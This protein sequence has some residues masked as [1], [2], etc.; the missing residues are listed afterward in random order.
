MRAYAVLSEILQRKGDVQNS[1]QS[2]H[3]VAAIRLSEK[4]DALHAAGLYGR[5]FDTYRDALELF[6]DAYCIQSRLAV[7][8]NKQGR[9]REA[10]EH[11][12]RAYEL[13]P[14]SFGRV[15]SHCFGCESVFQDSEAQG[16]AERVFSD[17]IRVTPGKAQAH[18]LLAYLRE[19][20]GDYEGAVQSLRS[21]VG[22]D[23]KYLNAWKRLHDIGDKTYLD[24]G[25]QDI[26]RLKLLELDP[27][28]RHSHY[29]LSE[30]AQ[31]G[32]L[33]RGAAVGREIARR[34]R[35]PSTGVF[36]LYATARARD[37]NLGSLPPE[38]R[39]QI[40]IMERLMESSADAGVARDPA[41]LLRDHALIQNAAAL[42]GL[43]ERLS[44][45]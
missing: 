29:D 44:D 40:S 9:R 12:R 36:A 25:E 11:Y 10:L 17:V 5:A 31:L 27:L 42:M 13:M 21:A 24:P 18:Y 23:G 35:V 8:L 15:E 20:K 4:A 30:V 7:Q 39:E 32:A 3:A 1:E 28:Q 22:I 14:E 34:A 38:M 16:I 33:W 43:Q 19:T 6:S 45:Y 2:A 41:L 37:E 26:A